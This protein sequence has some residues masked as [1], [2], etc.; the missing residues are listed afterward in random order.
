MKLDLGTR[1]SRLPVVRE[2]ASALPVG[3][4]PS[5][6]ESAAASMVA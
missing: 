3:G 4:L 2:R 6:A 5:A 1:R